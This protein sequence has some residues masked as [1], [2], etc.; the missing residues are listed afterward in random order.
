MMRPAVLPSAYRQPQPTTPT[1]QGW[2]TPTASPLARPCFFG[3]QSPLAAKSATATPSTADSFGGSGTFAV[4]VLGGSPTACATFGGSGHFPIGA[5]G[6][7]PTASGACGSVD[8]ADGTPTGASPS[9]RSRYLLP[10]LLNCPRTVEK[11]PN[12]YLLKRQP[13]VQQPPPPQAQP[14][15]AQPPQVQ[16]QRQQ[17]QPQPF[18]YPQSPQSHTRRLS[19]PVVRTAGAA[20][21]AAPL[22]PPPPQSPMAQHRA[23]P[24]QQATPPPQSPMAQHPAP[25]PQQ[26]LLPQQSPMAQ[27]RALP[28]QQAPPPPQSPMAPSEQAPPQP[29]VQL[30]AWMLYPD[31][32]EATISRSDTLGD[33]YNRLDTD[34]D[35]GISLLELLAAVQREPDI[36]AQV[37]PGIDCDRLMSDEDTF[38]A[39]SA[40]FDAMSGGRKRISRADFECYLR[41]RAGADAGA[42]E[43][44]S[45]ADA[46]LRAIFDRIDADGSGAISRLEVL[47]A[48]SGDPE[49]ARILGASPA[50]LGDED[51]YDAVLAAFDAMADGSRRVDFASFRAYVRN[52]GRGA[53]ARKR[54]A[55]APSTT[56][57]AD[58]VQV[59]V[60]VLAQGFE[61]LPMHQQLLSKAG[62]E[63][64]WLTEPQL[65]DAARVPAALLPQEAQ[66]ALRP[67]LEDFRP[68]VLVCAGRGCL[69][70]AALWAGG[71]AGTWTGA[72]VLISVPPCIGRLPHGP[73]VLVAQGAHDDLHRRTREDLERLLA[74][75]S[76]NSCAL[77]F[78]GSSGLLSGSGQV[79]RRGDDHNMASLL[80]HDCL[81]RLIDAACTEHP[82]LSLHRSW[83][84]QLSPQRLEAERWL[85]YGLERLRQRWESSG[86]SVQ[87]VHSEEAPAPKIL[88][89][90]SPHGE[91]FQ[92]VAA[93][94]RAGPTQTSIYGGC[95]Q[96]AWECVRILKIERVENGAQEEGAARVYAKSLQR[97]LEEQGIPMEAGT[98]SRW[99]F[100]G[101]TAVESIVGNP[102]A[103]F[104][105]LASG[106]R[107]ASL[108]GSGTYFARDAKYV[109]DGQF[110]GPPSPT[111]GSRRMLLCLLFTGMACLGDPQH[112]GVL[113]IR[114]GWHRYDSTVDSLANPEI[115]VVQHP[116][117]AYPAYV[118]TF[119]S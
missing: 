119:A 71:G 32:A 68:D 63:A 6:G 102:L 3:G 91:E 20:T 41:G 113:P 59:R 37:L 25:P 62:F 79:S 82:E 17:S 65:P 9:G 21:P 49:L 106:L 60:L 83:A 105:P 23:P 72:F 89:E 109:S 33:L 18:A 61:Q 93:L 81:P 51:S 117:A 16:P 48:A 14:P 74:T 103:G 84:G 90:V 80:T 4:G 111:D 78:S 7:S 15:Q 98:H 118:I 57:V 64:R 34:G 10:S 96:A 28:Q 54:A 67:A 47:A 104:Q 75:G 70:A 114:Q 87:A 94:F 56:A 12:A 44:Q 85:G 73:R 69:Y 5:L 40:I 53:D 19:I 11:K 112:R 24:Q 39:A 46:D 27:Q 35:G 22:A 38:D 100:H 42:Q 86:R 97:S 26:A 45:E 115:F 30:P 101:T 116:G 52:V 110:C 13:Q 1:S 8:V 43:A 88:F 92:R 36:A 108:W 76:P 66:R 107:G 77:Y 50:V 29:Q 2:A 31:P 99:A 58:R 55:A 95:A